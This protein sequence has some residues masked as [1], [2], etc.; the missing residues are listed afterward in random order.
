MQSFYY[1]SWFMC[2]GNLGG[3]WLGSL[4]HGPSPVAGSGTRAAG[5]C[6]ALSS[7]SLPCLPPKYL[8]AFPVVFVC[9]LVG[10]PHNVVPSGKVRLCIWGSGAPRAGELRDK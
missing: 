1:L 5:N 4:A 2:V 7:L 9:A 3:V 6:W 10:L 8:R